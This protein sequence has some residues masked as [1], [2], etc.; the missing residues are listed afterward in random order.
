MCLLFGFFSNMAVDKNLKTSCEEKNSIPKTHCRQ[1]ETVNITARAVW[2]L[3]VFCA[4]ICLSDR[5]N[6][7]VGASAA[8]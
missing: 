2:H 6:K 4:V 5:Q 3:T 1:S 8:V 7:A